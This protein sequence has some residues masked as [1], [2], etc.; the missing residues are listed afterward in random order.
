MTKSRNFLPE[1]H[2]NSRVQLVLL[3][4]PACH[5]IP[6]CSSI[7]S[8]G[9]Q[10]VQ[11]HPK[12]YASI[13]AASG[14]SLISWLYS[15]SMDPTFLRG[16]QTVEP[17]QLLE[18]QLRQRQQCDRL[19]RRQSA[20]VAA[21]EEVPCSLRFRLLLLLHNPICEWLGAIS[22]AFSCYLAF[23]PMILPLLGTNVSQSPPEPVSEGHLDP[24][25][26]VGSIAAHGKE[27][28]TLL[29]SQ[30]RLRACCPPPSYRV[31]CQC[32]CLLE[33]EYWI[34]VYRADTEIRHPRY[35]LR[36]DRHTA[37]PLQP[38]GGGRVCVFRHI[39]SAP[40]AHIV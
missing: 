18:S 10:A 36:N 7:L 8:K 1:Y 3:L 6:T 17:P 32:H 14:A 15:H 29:L 2:P 12:E 38:V 35:S 26:F 4:S 40:R 22:A 19:Q 24:L 28:P 20:V 25:L 31:H 34:V 5:Q 39:S 13:Q 30:A 27:D 16:L 23:D 33:L 21:S 9:L 11:R 37:A